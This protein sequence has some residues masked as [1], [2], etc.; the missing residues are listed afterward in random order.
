MKTVIEYLDDSKEKTGSDY[1]T[2][3]KAWNYKR[4]SFRDQKTRKN[5]R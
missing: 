5:E 3:K 1:M 2:A 4:I